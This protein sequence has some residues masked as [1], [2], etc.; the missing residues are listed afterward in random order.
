LKDFDDAAFSFE[1]K[2]FSSSAYRI[3]AIRTLGKILKFQ[4]KDLLDKDRF[5]E[6]DTRLVSWSLNLPK[7]KREVIRRGGEVD[8]MLLQAHLINKLYVPFTL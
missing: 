5:N 3:D 1:E 2:E 4:F 7:S 6:A 8:E